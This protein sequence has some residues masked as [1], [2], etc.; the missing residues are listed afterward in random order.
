MTENL[1]QK[2]GKVKEREERTFVNV[3]AHGGE[4]LFRDDSDKVKVQK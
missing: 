3:W 2:N 4:V 1:M